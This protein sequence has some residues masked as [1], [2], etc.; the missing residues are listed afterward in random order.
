M[1][2]I[3]KVDTPDKETDMEF[4]DEMLD[5]DNFIDMVVGGEEYTISRDDLETIVCAF[6]KRAEMLE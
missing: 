6:H 3:I 5:N 1:R 2:I 4:T